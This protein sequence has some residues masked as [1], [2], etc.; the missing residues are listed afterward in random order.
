MIR[1]KDVRVQVE[2]IGTVKGVT[3]W[4]LQ[5]PITLAFATDDCGFEITVPAGFRTDFASVPSWLH[6]LFPPAG[7]YAAVAVLHDWLYRKTTCS[8]FLADALFREGM[9]CFGVPLWQRVVMYYA[10][11]MCGGAARRTPL[12]R[13]S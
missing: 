9:A 10:V 2:L 6:W 4:E 11:R 13:L 7:K 1:P 3:W 5:E 12:P 8:R